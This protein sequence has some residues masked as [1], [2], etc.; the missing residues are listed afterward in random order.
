MRVKNIFKKKKSNKRKIYIVL[1]FL[2]FLFVSLYYYLSSNNNYVV[3]PVDENIF[4]IIPEEK[5]G[6]KVL[7][8]DKKSLN[9]KAQQEFVRIS[10]K[11]KDAYFSVQFYVDDDFE[12]VKKYLNKLNNSEESIYILKDFFIL[13]LNSEI[14]TDYFLLYKNFVSKDMAKKYCEDFLSKLDKCLIVDTTKF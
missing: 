14:S 9:L 3:I 5:G 4:Y 7:N 13:A 6:E 2:I 11:P 1:L 8:L 12:S 10:N